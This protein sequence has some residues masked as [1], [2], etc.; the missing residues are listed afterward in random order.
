MLERQE[1]TALMILAGVLG[2]LLFVH[3]ILGI[4]GPGAFASP[5]TQTSQEG[6]LVQLE[7]MVEE[8]STTSKG[9]HSIAVVNGVTIFIP[10]GIATEISLQQGDMAVVIGMV[11][12][13][14]GEKE[15]V[16][17]NREDIWIQN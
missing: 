1:R 16:V 9:A 15:I 14:K 5:F 6:E 12:I 11:Q 7:G 10:A 3:L 2:V 13:Y 8:V 17:K 4:I